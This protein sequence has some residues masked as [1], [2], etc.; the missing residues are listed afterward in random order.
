LAAP[1]GGSDATVTGSPG[2]REAASFRREAAAA[3]AAGPVCSLCSE[4][5]FLGERDAFSPFAQNEREVVSQTRSSASH[6]VQVG[7]GHPCGE[8][9]PRTP[10][11]R[12]QLGGRLMSA[13]NKG[14]RSLLKNSHDSA[15]NL[16]K[17]N[18]TFEPFS[19]QQWQR[20]TWCL[21][22]VGHPARLSGEM[23][24][25]ILPWTYPLELVPAHTP[26][27]GLSLLLRNKCE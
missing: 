10:G 1:P 5:A 20:A 15:S 24:I 13:R 7:L 23:V 6:R 16:L 12:C 8:S 2:S 21:L 9:A 25:A 17:S 3:A 18:R 19:E 27:T 26:P 14:G 4:P 11:L 22:A